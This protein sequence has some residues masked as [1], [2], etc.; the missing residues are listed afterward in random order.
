M[1]QS[2]S[3]NSYVVQTN[4]ATIN[5]S[6]A[7]ADRLSGG[8]SAALLQQVMNLTSQ[9][10]ELLPPQQKAQVLALQQQMVRAPVKLAFICQNNR[11]VL[12][13]TSSWI[14]RR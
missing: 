4:T 13:L 14:G 8:A 11:N 7:K 3:L 1:L 5:C 12:P 2:L 10:I 9:Q 6:I